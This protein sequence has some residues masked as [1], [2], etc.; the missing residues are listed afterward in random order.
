MVVSGQPSAITCFKEHDDIITYRLA[1]VKRN[2]QTHNHC[3]F[4]DVSETRG[5]EHLKLGWNMA[6]NT[7]KQ[8]PPEPHDH[9]LNA[10]D[11][12]PQPT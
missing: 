5:L 4:A 3:G 6:W 7:Q 1:F 10:F 8:T 11:W 9:P 12:V 2:R